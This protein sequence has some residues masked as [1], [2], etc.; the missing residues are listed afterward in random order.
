MKS[1]LFLCAAIG[2]EVTASLS[3]K[4]A[5][6]FPLLYIVVAIGYIASFTCLS[7]SLKHGMPLGVAYGIWGAIGVILTALL[8]ALIFHEPLSALMGIGIALI[9]AGVLTVEIGSQRAGHTQSQNMDA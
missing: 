5:L 3:L 9:V 2:T 8:S 6:T 7:F 4:G 1:W